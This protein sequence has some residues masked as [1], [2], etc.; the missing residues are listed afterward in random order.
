MPKMTKTEQLINGVLKSGYKEIK[1]KSGKY[2]TF[3][4]PGQSPDFLKLFIGRNAA[5]RYGKTVSKSFSASH[6]PIYKMFMEK[7]KEK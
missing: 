6:N 5:L 7:G 2:R 3:I 1:S 4:L